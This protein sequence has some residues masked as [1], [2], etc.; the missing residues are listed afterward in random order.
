MLA[1]LQDTSLAGFAEAAGD[2]ASYGVKIV[3][4]QR[5]KLSTLTVRDDLLVLVLKGSKG[6]H[7]PRSVLTARSNEAVLMARGTQWDVVNDPQGALQFESVVLSFSNPLIQKFNTAYPTQGQPP[8]KQASV[9]AADEALQEAVKRMLPTAHGGGA[10]S[11]AVLEH[12]AM[13][14]L[15]LLS[16]KGLRFACLQSISWADKVRRL[17]AQR[18]HAEWHAGALCDLLHL[19]ESTLRRRLHE[20][21]TTLAGLVREV[22]LEAAL[23]LLQTSAMPVGEVAQRCGWASHSR[24]SSAFQLRWG[25]MPS[26]VRARLTQAE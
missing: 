25:V 23:N 15:L 2:E 16:L 4:A 21:G 22:R 17:V 13:E 12:R 8:I 3:A 11:A 1:A 18:P 7:T 24:F 10:V 9:V 26:V 14:V 19:S 20:S 6:L 5:Y